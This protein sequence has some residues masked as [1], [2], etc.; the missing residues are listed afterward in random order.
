LGSL[1]GSGVVVVTAVVEA[2]D[3]KDDEADVE[4]VVVAVEVAVEECDVVAELVA[5]EVTV[6]VSVV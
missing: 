1:Q 6:V 3:V 5:D 4:A 2:L